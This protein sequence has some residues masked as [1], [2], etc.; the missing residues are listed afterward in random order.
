MSN[1]VLEL[2]LRSRHLV[3]RGQRQ[4]SL[5]EPEDRISTPVHR[6]GST[7][8]RLPAT[9]PF[10]RKQHLRA[11][12]AEIGRMPEG[13]VRIG[14]GV[15]T[16]RIYRVRDIEQNAVTRTRAGSQTQVRAHS[17]VVATPS[18]RC[19]LGTFSMIAALP[20]PVGISGLRISKDPR[21]GYDLRLLRMRQRHLDHD[22]SE[23]RSIRVFVGIPSRTSC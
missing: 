16:D 13:V 3:V 22:N 14:N 17:D 1:T 23:Q 18:H 20:K 7:A 10:V 4:L 19:R 11:V 9:A 12:V 21:T 5:V 6:I 15:D 2:A 8:T